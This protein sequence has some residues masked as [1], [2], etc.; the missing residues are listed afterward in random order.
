[1]VQM[2]M[3][4]NEGGDFHVGEKVRST[5]VRSPGVPSWASD[6]LRWKRDEAVG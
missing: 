4:Q 6:W 3:A 5:P 2:M 1:M